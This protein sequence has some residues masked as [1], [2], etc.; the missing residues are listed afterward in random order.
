MG[1]IIQN[2]KQ[3][4]PVYSELPPRKWLINPSVMQDAFDAPN[5]TTNGYAYIP[6]LHKAQNDRTNQYIRV[7]GRTTFNGE[8][9]TCVVQLYGVGV[10][11]FAILNKIEA[12]M[13]NKLVA[14]L[15]KL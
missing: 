10:G 1:M 6:Y 3:Y 4:S 2:G 9:Y 5:K 7:N 13:Y 12:R 14:Y 8:S 11:A 15:S